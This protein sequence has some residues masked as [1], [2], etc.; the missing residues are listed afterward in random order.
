MIRCFRTISFV[1]EFGFICDDFFQMRQLQSSAPSSTGAGRRMSVELLGDGGGGARRRSLGASGEEEKTRLDVQRALDKMQV[2]RVPVVVLVAIP[3]QLK[4]LIVP[5]ITC[6]WCSR[7]S[8]TVYSSS[9]A[10]VCGP[11]SCLTIL[12]SSLFAVSRRIIV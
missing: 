8:H 2:M 3:Q 9:R 4:H 6:M 10:V 1:A 5:R 12:H 7:T 11:I